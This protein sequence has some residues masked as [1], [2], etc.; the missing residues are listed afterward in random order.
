MIENKAKRS[1][2]KALQIGERAVQRETIGS[3]RYTLAS[4]SVW[5]ASW[6][7]CAVKTAVHSG[8]KRQ[9]KGVTD[10]EQSPNA[11]EGGAA[12]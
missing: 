7:G 2:E 8:D 11:P 6:L 1:G 3:R 10:H 4:E 9:V 12:A 5:I